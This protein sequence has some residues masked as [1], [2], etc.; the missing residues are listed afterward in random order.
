MN[1]NGCILADARRVCASCCETAPCP[2]QPVLQQRGRFMPAIL[3]ACFTY[4]PVN[5]ETLLIVPMLRVG[6]PPTTVI[7]TEGRNL[8]SF[9]HSLSNGL[10]GLN[11]NWNYK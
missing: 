6:T 3:Q 2:A 10:F 1:W 4:K 9:L 11:A 8:A 7:S 5:R